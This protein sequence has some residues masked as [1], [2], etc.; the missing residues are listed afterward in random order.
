MFLIY[1]LDG[2]GRCNLSC[3]NVGFRRES[4]PAPRKRDSPWNPAWE[5]IA[6]LP[7]SSLDK[8]DRMWK[9]LALGWFILC[10]FEDGVFLGNKCAYLAFWLIHMGLRAMGVSLL[11]WG[12]AVELSSSGTALAWIAGREHVEKEDVLA[13]RSGLLGLI[14]DGLTR[15]ARRNGIAGYFSRLVRDESGYRS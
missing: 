3:G 13:G 6:V 12:G 10:W 14:G 2:G 8:V 11:G 9:W 1:L 5:P 4:I 15:I 7:L